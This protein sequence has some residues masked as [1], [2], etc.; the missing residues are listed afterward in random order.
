MTPTTIEALRRGWR[1]EDFRPG[2]Y[3]RTIADRGGMIVGRP[4]LKCWP[5]TLW[6]KAFRE[7]ETI[8]IEWE[9]LIPDLND[10]ATFALALAV[11]AHRSGLPESVVPYAWWRWRDNDRWV[12]ELAAGTPHRDFVCAEPDPIEAL[13]VAL[14]Q[15]AEV[16]P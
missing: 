1:A 2:M 12:L 11:L 14:A 8:W 3:V 10:A 16:K 6:N 13:A 4:V 5:V 9:L 7:Y 15:T